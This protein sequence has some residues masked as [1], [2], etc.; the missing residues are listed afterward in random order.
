MIMASPNNVPIPDLLKAIIH[1]LPLKNDMTENETVYKCVLG[2]LQMNNV[3]IT[4]FKADLKRVFSEA[5]AEGS[6]VDDE[7]KQKISLAF[8]AL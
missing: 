7:T 5:V 8:S 3:E 2:L 4:P 6:R 1:N